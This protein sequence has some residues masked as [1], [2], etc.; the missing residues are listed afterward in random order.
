M[1]TASTTDE[2]LCVSHHT[3]SVIAS[4]KPLAL[5]GWS[6]ELLERRCEADNEPR[7]VDN[8]SD[9]TTAEVSRYEP[10]LRDC[11]PIR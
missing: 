5:S 1:P 4:T 9:H 10:A 6:R 2:P 8:L 7:I 3:P 11:S